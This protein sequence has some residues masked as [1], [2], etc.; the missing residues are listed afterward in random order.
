MCL[1]PCSAR[2]LLWLAISQC[3]SGFGPTGCPV[4]FLLVL[5]APAPCP[6]GTGPQVFGN[7]NAPPAV[8][9]SAIIY[10]LRCMVTRDIPLN[11]GCMA[12]ITVRI[13]AGDFERCCCREEGKSGAV[14][15]LC[16]ASTACQPL[17]HGLLLCRAPRCWALTVQ[18]AAVLLPAPGLQARCCRPHPMLRWWVAMC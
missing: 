11:H 17:E 3:D 13:P 1:G 8:T 2:L 14:C 15:G 10:S 5:L 18:A 4:C 7:T 9:H 6:A 12:P 16:L